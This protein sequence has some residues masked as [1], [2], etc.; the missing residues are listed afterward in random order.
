M[1]KLNAKERDLLQRVETKPELEPFFFRKLKGLHWFDPLYERGFLLPEKNPKPQPAKEEGYVSI[2]SWPVTQYLVTASQELCDPNNEDY[3][4]KF[5]N[6]IRKITCHAKAE[7]YSNYGTWWQLAKVI[8]NIPPHLVSVEDIDLIDYW[9]DDT[10]NRG[11]VAEEI[12]EKWLPKL[13]EGNDEPSQQIALRVLDILY[14]TNFAVKKPGSYKKKETTLRYDPWYAKKITKKVARLS[15]RKLGLPAVELL[16]GRLISILNEHDNDDWSYIWRS[17]IEEHKQDLVHDT[18]D[19][20]IV[21]AYRD[22]LLGFVDSDV[23]AATIHLRTLFDCQYQTLKRVAIHMVDEKYDVLH[24]LV[25][26]VLHSEFF[27]S[28]YRHEVWHFLNNHYKEFN[29]NQEKKVIDIIEGLEELD[30]VGSVNERAT[31]YKRVIWFSAT[32]DYNEKIAQLYNKYTKIA[33]VE[34]E[35]PDFASYFTSGWVDHKSPIPLEYLLSL[36]V[37]SLVDTLNKYEDPGRFHEP[38]LEGLV[39]CFKELAK[40]KAKEL[41]P[42]LMKFITSDLA[43]VYVLVEA[44]HELWSEKKELP[45]M[46]VWPYLLDFC[47]ELAKRDEFWSDENAKER[48]HFVANRHWVVGAMGRLIEDGTKSDEHAFDKSLLPRAEQILLLLLDRQEGREF[49]RESDAVFV[50][51][52][53]PRGHCIE[54]LINLSLRS[55]RLADKEYGNHVQ[56]WNK[57]EA[58]Y[59][60]EL[61]RNKR[62]EYEFVTLVAMYIPN[63]L[64]M[65]REWSQSHLSEIFDQSDYQKWLCAMHGYAHVSAVYKEIYKHLKEN[66]DFLKALDDENLKKNVAEK[67]VE[68]IVVSYIIGGEDINQHDSLINALIARKKPDELGHLIWFIWTMREEDNEELR[69]KVFELWPRLIDIIDMNSKEG[70]TLASKLCDWA[71]FVKQI[72]KTTENWLLKIAPYAEEAYNS[73][74]LLKNLA[75]ISNYQPLEA[76]KIWVKMLESYSYDYPEDAIRQVF[77]NLIAL[78]VEGERKAKEIVDAYLRHG[79]DRPRTWLN[80]LKNLTE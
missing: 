25:D 5:V 53:S 76:Q 54:A 7:K 62:G 35:H 20:I 61:K 12:G 71:V 15:G 67:A 38:G 32:K 51:I 22:C 79:I 1:R 4:Q 28:N 24:S 42:E 55:C 57:H 46:D 44:Y 11:L 60:A 30:D 39:K 73:Y 31:A 49:K 40:T 14:K 63:F 45:W 37:D 69:R 3:A 70:R 41:Y 2:T 50:A 10:Y 36:N 48:T 29:Y 75:R 65:S 78:G 34:P 21:S 6:L 17:A 26:D 19:H 68:N 33:G 13:L 47:L 9:L 56:A 23:K 74:E 72:D 18:A 66:G 43:F 59:E 77:S 80:E 8:Q 27:K 52:N 58:I 16:Q 64:Y